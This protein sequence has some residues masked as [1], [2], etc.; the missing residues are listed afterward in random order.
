MSA[1]QAAGRGSASVRP[2]HR[3]AG[4]G[5]LAPVFLRIKTQEAIYS[6]ALNSLYI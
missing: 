4:R 5:K 6:T 1:G 2:D 3:P